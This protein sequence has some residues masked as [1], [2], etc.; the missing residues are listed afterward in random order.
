MGGSAIE[1]MVLIGN[2]T[3]MNKA[4]IARPRQEQRQANPESDPDALRPLILLDTLS[5]AHQS[6]SL[7]NFPNY[8]TSSV[9]NILGQKEVIP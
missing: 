7:P 1:E 2:Q 9:I 6:P 5:Q 3:V 8:S 4:G